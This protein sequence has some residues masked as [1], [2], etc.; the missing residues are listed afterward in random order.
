MR[1]FQAGAVTIDEPLQCRS[2]FPEAS[3]FDQVLPELL[4]HAVEYRGGIVWTH[5]QRP[6]AC[7][8]LE[9]AED[10][11]AARRVHAADIGRLHDFRQL[12][13]EGQMPVAQEEADLR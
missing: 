1:R 2:V 6:W 7:G 13:V 12:H 5:E 11:A 4:A 8:V 9:D 10:R 3:L